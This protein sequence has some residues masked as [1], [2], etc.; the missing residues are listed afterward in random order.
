MAVQFSKKNFFSKKILPY[1]EGQ[2]C[3]ILPY[4]EGRRAIQVSSLFGKE[5]FENEAFC[6]APFPFF[7][8]QKLD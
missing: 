4:L 3:T 2:K 1:L 7:E 6:K 5:A 8:L